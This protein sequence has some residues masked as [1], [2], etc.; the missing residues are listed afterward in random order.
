MHL[1][2]GTTEYEG[3]FKNG[4]LGD[5]I[6]GLAN[7][8]AKRDDFEISI[9]LPNYKKLKD[10]GFKDIGEFEI[11]NKNM[12]INADS[13]KLKGK[14]LYKKLKGVNAYL[15][16][17]DYYFYRDSIH[18]QNDEIVRWAF[19]CRG[20]YE[21]I[22][23]KSLN[24]D[25]IQTNDYHEG[26]VTSICK[27]NENDLNCKYVVSIHNAFIR[28]IY[29]YNEDNPKDLFEYYLGF[30]W[31]DDQVDMLECSVSTADYVLTV[32]PDYAESIKDP[33][34][35]ISA[36]LQDLYRE[37]NV[38][39][40]LNGLDASIYDRY[41]NNFNSFLKVKEKSKL[42]LQKKLNLKVDKDIPLFSYICRISEQKGSPIVYDNLENIV[43]DGQFVLLGIGTEECN[44]KFGELNGKLDN[45]VAC[46]YFD[47]ELAKEIYLASDFFLMP[48][49]FEP[50]GIAQ[51][52][53]LY[54]ATLP[55]VT[56]IGGLKETVNDYKSNNGNG[57]KLKDYS[58]ESLCDT[59][60]IAKNVYF[61]DKELL[62]KLMNN[63]YCSDYSWDNAIENYIK[64]Y[65]KILNE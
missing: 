24:P 28:N 22:I 34:S 56:N 65:Y 54:Y 43:N 62:F 6:F 15:I 26:F 61:N 52:I 46:I 9:I 23:Q 30:K 21:L 7:A 3:L 63:A 31:E 10:D 51:L 37:K 19:F 25:I 20:I 13:N 18:N 64:F 45:Y 4:G 29:K 49:Y 32:S 27:A 39:G 59:I 11:K 36:G 50:C 53:A 38:I 55:I 58:S 35:N 1:I 48:S 57:F 12:T 60:K 16:E 42:E 33:N 44:I 14:F 8:F 41:S 47:T 40:F 5:A 17:N 2:I